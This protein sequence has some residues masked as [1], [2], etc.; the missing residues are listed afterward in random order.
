MPY[1]LKSVSSAEDWRAYHS[2][3]KTVLFVDRDYD[4]QH[5]DE[6]LPQHFPL[7]LMLGDTPVATVRLDLWTETSAVMRLVAV[8]PG[9]QNKGHGTA[10]YEGLAQFAAT[11]GVKQLLVN[12]APEAVGYY[13]KLGFTSEIWDAAELEGVAQG[14]VQMS[15]TL[16]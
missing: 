13:S 10:L 5:G 16:A 6:Y 14:C 12:A 2:I 15:R 3:R 8:A 7:L 4:E 11:K 1:F 9:E